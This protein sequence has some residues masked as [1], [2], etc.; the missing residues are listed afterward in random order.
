MKKRIIILGAA[1]CQVPLIKHAQ[2]IGYTVIVIS[3]D[4]NYPGFLIADKSYEIDVRDHEKILK[5]AR[6]EKISG[7][8]TDQTDIPVLTAAYVAKSLG[9]PG[10]GIECAQR[11]TNKYKMRQ[12]CEQLGIPVPRYTQASSIDEALKL[13]QKFQ[14]PLVLKPVD[15]QGSRGVIKISTRNELK[16]VFNNVIL[17]S[18]VQQVILEEFF[19]GKEIVI[20]GFISAN[21]FTNLIIGDREYFDLPNL[22][23]PRKT[24]FP[25]QL[26][27][28]LQKKIIKLNTKLIKGFSPSF[29][30]THSEFLVNEKTGDVCLIETAIRG[31]GAFIS[32]DLIPLVS[33]VDVN[34]SLIL[35]ASG[36][37]AVPI[38][39]RQ[40][41]HRAAAYMC[42]HL[43]EGQIQSIHGLQEVLAIS[44]VQKAFFQ[45]VRVGMI[46]STITDKTTRHGPILIAAEKYIDLQKVMA[47][48][49]NTLIIKVR[50]P[51]GIQGIIW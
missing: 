34:K 30:I 2:K 7:I 4:G 12:Y 37:Q 6:K 5:V 15:S 29:G 13:T 26:K 31:G 36:E 38:E 19:Q 50:T 23:I 14:F 16:S 25:S 11:F 49:K 45:E 28:E 47:E 20:E 46:T 42:F 39:S 10:I 1:E 24:I 51:E 32:S 48:V 18:S 21:T 33:N 35:L 43:P 41:K 44:G 27:P 9:L 8:L 3:R 22:F 17:H 40:L